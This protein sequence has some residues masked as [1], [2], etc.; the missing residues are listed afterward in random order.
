[1]RYALRERR[2]FVVLL[3]ACAL[4]YFGFHAVRDR[5]PAGF[6][7][8]SLPS[9]LTPLAMFGVVELIPS[10]RFR[11]RAIKFAVLAATTLIAAIWLEAVVPRFTQR[12]SGDVGD[13]VAM[14]VGFVL[15]C[16]YDLAFGRRP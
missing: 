6:L 1:V 10:I 14:A 7:H 8:D 16:M 3:G 4:A 13:A 9:L 15:F 11:K 2:P 12:A 5:L